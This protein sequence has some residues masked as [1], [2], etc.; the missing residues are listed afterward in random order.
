MKLFYKNIKIHLILHSLF[1]SSIIEYI[2]S[3]YIDIYSNLLIKSLSVSY[4]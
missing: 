4:V 3:G 1:L 2:S